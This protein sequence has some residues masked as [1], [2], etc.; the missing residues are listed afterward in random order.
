M[1]KDK[2]F[3]YIKCIW[4]LWLILVFLSFVSSFTI[5]LCLNKH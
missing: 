4:E 1:I 5:Q 2:Y 3:G